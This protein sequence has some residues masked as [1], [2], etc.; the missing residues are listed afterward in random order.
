MD[1]SNEMFS[2]VLDYI[3]NY[4]QKIKINNKYGLFDEA[5]MFELF[6]LEICKIWFGQS[7]KNLN[8]EVKNYPFVDLVSDDGQKYIQVTTT[9]DVPSKI[10]NTLEGIR[11]SS[12]PEVRDIKEVFFFVMG[13]ESIERVKDFKG[14]NRI[15][16]VEFCKEENLIS[17]DSILN[18]AQNDIRF[19]RSLYAILHD[20]FA[21]IPLV[22]H[23]LD[24]EIHKSKSLIDYS[25]SYLINNEYEIDRRDLRKKIEKT[26]SRFVCIQGE[27]GSGKSALGK[28]LLEKENALLFARSEIFAS[29][30]SIS[31]IWGLDLAHLLGLLEGKRIVFYIDALEFIAD[32]GKTKID[33]LFEL[34][35]LVKRFSCAS[36]VV[37]CRTCDSSAF[38]RIWNAFPFLRID[39]PQLSEDEIRLLSVK[40]QIIKELLSSKSY[41]QLL[42]SPFYIDLIV[43]K[44]KNLSEIT[45]VSEFRNE[46][47]EKAICLQDKDIPKTIS[48]RQIRETVILIVLSRAENNSV[49]VVKDEYDDEI[50]RVLRSYEV[51]TDCSSTRIRLKYDIYEDIVFEHLIDGWF[52]ACR[53]NR[54]VFFEKINSIG[55]AIYRRYQ[56]WVG[57]KL[58][59]KEEST[60]YLFDTIKAGGSEYWKKQT[61]IGIIKSFFCGLFF[62]SFASLFDDNLLLLFIEIVNKYSFEVTVNSCTHGNCFT[63]LN[64]TG[65]SRKYLIGLLMD[66]K[67]YQTNEFREAAI[68][69]CSDYSIEVQ[70]GNNNEDAAQ[71]AFRILKYFFVQ[72]YEQ[73]KASRF[74]SFEPEMKELLGSIYRMAVV[75]GSW[76]ETFWESII[77]GYRKD[78]NALRSYYGTIMLFSLKESS[79][80]LSKHLSKKLCEL[81]SVYW[82]ENNDSDKRWRYGYRDIGGFG[83]SINAD[84]YTSS[85]NQPD[86]NLF[87]VGLARFDFSRALSWVIDLTNKVANYFEE[88]PEYTLFEYS[89]RLDDG[90]S[91]VFMGNPD[92]WMVGLDEF[93]LNNLLGDAIYLLEREAADYIV[94]LKRYGKHQ[95]FANKVKKSILEKANNIMMLAL[96]ERLA[97]R[98]PFDLPGYA[99]ELASNVDLLLLDNN[100]FARLHPTS[101]MKYLEKQI[102]AGFGLFDIKKR[103]SIDKDFKETTL[104]TY[105]IRLQLQGDD[106]I[107]TRAKETLDF[108]YR[109]YPNDIENAFYNLQIQKMDISKMAL[110]KRAA[111]TVELTT[112]VSGEAK[113][114]VEK[115]KE[116]PII[117][118]QQ[119]SLE[120]MEHLV[121]KINAQEESEN[122]L[123][124][125]IDAIDC[126]LNLLDGAVNTI[127][128]Q[129]NLNVL[130]FFALKQTDLPP[131][132]LTQYSD[133]CID[134]IRNYI[135]RK[136]VYIAP[137][138]ADVVFSLIE[139]PLEERTQNKLKKLILDILLITDS[140]GGSIDVVSRLHEYLKTNT[141]F[142]R[143]LLNTVVVI[144]EDRMNRFIYTAQCAEDYKLYEM[145]YIPN[146]NTPPLFIEQYFKKK[147]IPVYQS[148]V[149]DII[150]KYLFDEEPLNYEDWSIEKCDISTLCCA[151]NCGLLL[152][153][154]VFFLVAHTV[155]KE[156]FAIKNSCR[157]RAYS[158]FLNHF[159][160]LRVEEYFKK[161]ISAEKQVDK[162]LEI[163]F[164]EDCLSFH[165]DEVFQIYDG[166]TS[167]LQTMYFDA[168]EDKEKRRSIERIFGKIEERLDNIHNVK[169][170][171]RLSRMM[172]VYT[173]MM[174]QTDLNDYNTCYSYADKQF[175]NCL[176][177]KYGKYHFQ[178]LMNLIYHYHIADLLPDVLIPIHKS[179]LALISGKNPSVV[180]SVDSLLN[181]VF[182]KAVVDFNNHIKQDDQLSQALEGSLELLD[183]VGIKFASVLLDEFRVH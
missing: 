71:N 154:E 119:K 96:I 47:W 177:G 109:L 18:R 48:R 69:I 158:D 137:Y 135:D 6:G 105:F 136:P 120:I 7:F 11:D 85:F 175:L 162:V 54:H 100:R 63:C 92:F 145:K 56:I 159:S 139:R 15:G 75:S 45:T 57:N 40:Y 150:K 39:V 35:D 156:I 31:D 77:E 24:E 52:D 164:S 113:K 81:A 61:I 169:I 65:E 115:G 107:K 4:R 149:D 17:T 28:K 161:V 80:S 87:L 90:F 147:K 163:F 88:N 43:S 180:L 13:N 19:L 41:S 2:F 110:I 146:R 106:R 108:L 72:E 125:C 155:L 25:I 97:F 20:E 153:D 16:R 104:Q 141:E 44:L 70:N 23:K 84:N 134:W 78:E 33:L 29:V 26:S 49:G 9:E 116:S 167:Y 62:D 178:D 59:S 73:E 126:F 60:K 12:K 102:M 160:V 55:H 14:E 157:R 118:E 101:D 22:A 64:P 30:T 133:I 173:G 143:S 121:A 114:I 138:L 34:F 142:A 50:I 86:T 128:I 27:A 172:F 127:A 46:V 68:T 165:C 144:S 98:F 103:Y 152:D 166:L 58:M 89:I 129:Q 174:F 132:K 111:S 38:L 168:F 94:F 42:K 182:T 181:L 179:L 8:C 117:K 5:K 171:I 124:E 67:R 76:I 176:W 37:T 10:K 112:H 66:N 140:F 93:R 82:I 99:L 123:K 3:S 148:R 170:R 21:S 51:I 95:V 83:L 131:E 79:V 74:P 183:S 151:I 91:K 1:R 53:G 32:A 36:I 122:L 130:L